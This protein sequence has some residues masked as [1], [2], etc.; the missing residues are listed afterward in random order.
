M[1]IKFVIVSFLVA[2]VK[3][4]RFA[5]VGVLFGFKLNDCVILSKLLLFLIV[6]ES[7]VILFLVVSHFYRVT[8]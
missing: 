2:A 3:E 1:P 5:D 4:V 8:N 7:G 6:P